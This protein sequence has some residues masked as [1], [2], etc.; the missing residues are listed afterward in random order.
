L[1]ATAS[2]RDV[3]I[4]LYSIG[5]MIWATRF[6]WMLKALGFDRAA[7]LDGGFD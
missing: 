5:T 1:G 3:R 6:W 4:V 7:M 2:A